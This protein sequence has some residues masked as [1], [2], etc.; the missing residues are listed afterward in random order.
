MNPADGDKSAE[1][2]TEVSNWEHPS[3]ARDMRHVVA[4][5]DKALFVIDTLK[6]GDKPRQMFFANGNWI[7]PTWVK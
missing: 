4:N 3:W 7:S 5:R 2:I 6:D 1:L